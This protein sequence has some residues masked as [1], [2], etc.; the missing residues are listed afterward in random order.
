MVFDLDYFKRVNDTYGH[1]TGDRVLKHT[2][3][4]LAAAKRGEDTLGRIGGEEFVLLLPDLSAPAA[5]QAAERLQ[6]RLA[7]S[8]IEAE[9]KT[10]NVT[11]SGGGAVFPEDGGDWDSL[12]AVADKRCYASKQAGHNRVMGLT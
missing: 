9:G 12:F 5:L 8:S 4:I 3:D 6:L 11:M 10:I 2:A 7:E 1:L